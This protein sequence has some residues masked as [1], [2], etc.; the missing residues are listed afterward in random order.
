MRYSACNGNGECTDICANVMT[1]RMS[2]KL[3][4]EKIVSSVA[5]DDFPPSL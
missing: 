3:R 5:T 2:F 4:I 1:H